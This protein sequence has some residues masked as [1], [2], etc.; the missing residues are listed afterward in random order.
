[1]NMLLLSGMTTV[2]N[3]KDLYLKCYVLSL[4]DVFEKFKNNSLK[5][6]SYARVII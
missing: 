5:I 3:Y 1:M 6:M 4:A 2:K